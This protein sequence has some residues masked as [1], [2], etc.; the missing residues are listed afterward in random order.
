MLPAQIVTEPD[1]LDA[2]NYQVVI[3]RTRNI[4]IRRRLERE[5]LLVINSSK[6]ALIGNDKLA[7]FSF[8][9]N[10]G[11]PVVDTTTSA[12]MP[13]SNS[14][15]IKPR[16]GHGGNGVR[17]ARLPGW[18]F[19]GFVA[20]PFL[21]GA[22][23]DERAYVIGS[24][25]AAWV[26]RNN[27]T[28]F[29]SNLSQGATPRI[30]TP[31]KESL[32]IATRIIELLGPGYYGIDIFE[33]DEGPAVNEIEDVVGARSLYQLGLADPARLLIGWIALQLGEH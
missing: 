21:P 17:L 28:D 22:N 27:Q 32:L 14:A 33:T 26:G 3:A 10:N 23:S 11:L 25:V 4:S 9:K 18:S 24:S 5:G 15:V 7:T 12:R 1:K 31:S 13:P 20:Q 8:L 19:D 16:F 30:V 2:R 6:L 29:R